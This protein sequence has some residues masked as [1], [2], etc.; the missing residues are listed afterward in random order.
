MTPTGR[1]FTGLIGQFAGCTGG[2]DC[3]RK[4]LR[5]AVQEHEIFQ[6]MEALGWLC[7]RNRINLLGIA[8]FAIYRP[9]VSGLRS[10]RDR[11]GSAV[12]KPYL[13]PQPIPDPCRK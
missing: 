12:K 5:P 4:Y 13:V 1:G 3:N 11:T 6:V 8:T 10:Q 7:R 2:K 9:V